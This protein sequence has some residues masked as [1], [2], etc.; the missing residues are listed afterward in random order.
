MIESQRKADSQDEQDRQYHAL[1]KI[2]QRDAGEIDGDDDD[3]SRDHIR[4]NRADKESF[5]TLENYAAGIAAM[6]QVERPFYDRRAT[7]DRALQFERTP[8]D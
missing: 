4:H 8:D 7:A 6:F 3:F 5:F 1:I 2:G